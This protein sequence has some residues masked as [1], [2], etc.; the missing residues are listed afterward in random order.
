MEFGKARVIDRCIVDRFACSSRSRV[1]PTSSHFSGLEGPKLGSN[2]QLSTGNNDT[3]QSFHFCLCTQTLQERLVC[4]G[5]YLRALAEASWACSVREEGESVVQE[6][7]SCTFSP[8]LDRSN[9]GLTHI[10]GE[11]FWVTDAI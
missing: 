7:Y 5:V 10:L 1:L 6:M 9:F 2:V 4:D 8:T 11:Y 3:Y